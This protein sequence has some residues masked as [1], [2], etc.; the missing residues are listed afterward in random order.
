M[1]LFNAGHFVLHSGATT[2]FKI[3]EE[4]LT[5]A[6]IEALA[7]L[8]YLVVPTFSKAVGIPRGGVRLAQAMQ[9]HANGEGPILIV[10][11]VLTTGASMNKMLHEYPG[12]HGLVIFARKVLPLEYPVVALFCI[13][14][15]LQGI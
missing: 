12:S 14:P 8:A 2:G 15:R 4:A 6:D 13:N 10:D 11:D 3:D 5:D 1:S 9:R 7:G